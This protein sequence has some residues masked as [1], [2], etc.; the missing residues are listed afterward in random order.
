MRQNYVS[1]STAQIS[2]IGCKFIYCGT[3]KTCAKQYTGNKGSVVIEFTNGVQ[4]YLSELE[5]VVTE[6]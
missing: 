2:Y 3:V 5:L 4:V 6:L 1:T